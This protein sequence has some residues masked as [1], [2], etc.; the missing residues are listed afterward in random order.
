MLQ[1]WECALEKC[2]ELV[3][4]YEEETFDYEQLSQ[5]H[6]RMADFYDNIMK[7]IR[8]RPEYFRV[9]YYGRGF[10]KF[11]QN[12]VFIYRG[13]DYERISEFSSRILNEFPHAQPLNKLTP[14]EREILESN[15]QCILASK[16]ANF[17]FMNKWIILNDSF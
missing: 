4:Q 16:L 15:G 17:I 13:K 5:L 8:P 1:M 6:R 9:G 3:K 2:Q 11:L 10:P 14:P 7:K 12:K